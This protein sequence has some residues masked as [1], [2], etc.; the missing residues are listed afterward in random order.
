MHAQKA[1]NIARL[2]ALTVVVFSLSLQSG[3]AQ[4]QKNL[5]VDLVQV[6][7][8]LKNA[9]LREALQKLITQSGLQIVYNDA[10][11]NGLL[12]S[13]ECKNVSVRQ[14][15][16]SLLADTPLSYQRLKNGQVVIIKKQPDKKV[17]LSGTVR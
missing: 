5:E 12:V 16:D 9:P 2:I 14:A 6:R 8:A 1:K 4:T 11:V 7:F 15:L 13:C 3:L 10:L 17:D